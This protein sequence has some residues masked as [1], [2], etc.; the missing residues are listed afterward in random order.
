VRIFER[1]LAADQLNFVEL[2]VLQ[3]ALALHFDHRAFV[4]HKIMDGEIFFQ[5]IINAVQPALFQ[6]GEVQRR[7]AQRFAWNGPRVD[8][9]SPDHG[10]ALDDRHALAEVRRLG[11][12]LFAGRPTADDHQ[13]KLLRSSH[14]ILHRMDANQVEVRMHTKRT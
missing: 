14:E 3:D 5:R 6:P 1:S 9:T 13:I 4:V 12:G 8:A 7:L 10:R 11:A 2:Q